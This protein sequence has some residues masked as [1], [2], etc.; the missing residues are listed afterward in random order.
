MSYWTQFSFDEIK[1]MQ[2]R[3]IDDEDDHA[4]IEDKDEEEDRVYC[5]KRGCESCL[6]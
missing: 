5:C 4:I 6:L 2:G 1:A 3:E